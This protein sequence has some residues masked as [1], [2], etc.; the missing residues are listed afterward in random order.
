[1]GQYHKFINFDKKQICEPSFPKKL[2]EWSYQ[3][4]RYLNAIGVLLTNEWKGDRVLCVGDYVDEFYDDPQ[5]KRLFDEI[6]N[7][8][9]DQEEYN[10]Y[11]YKFEEIRKNSSPRLF[12]R[13]IYNHKSKEY[14]DLKRQP[15]Q[16]CYYDEKNNLVGGVKIN[17]LSLLL[18]CSNGA[19]GGD[20]YSINM[21]KVGMWTGESSFLELSNKKIDNNYKELDFI[22]NERNIIE[23]DAEILSGFIIDKY[24]KN[25]ISDMSK[26]K[27]DKQLFLTQNEKNYIF[28]LAISKFNSL[29]Q[30]KKSNL[31]L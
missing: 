9:K 11:D 17:P 22:F 4:N 26:I 13:Y 12:P 1:M 3:G 20:Y 2:M 15:I 5:F 18:S 7:E 23:S 29:E 27:F 14:I 21:D 10:I 28:D 24:N 25:E 31:E 8:N 30:D 16:W 6:I 19:G